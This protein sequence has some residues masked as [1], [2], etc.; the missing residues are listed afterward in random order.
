MTINL[1]D[2]RKALGETGYVNAIWS[3][4]DK[5]SGPIPEPHIRGWR[6]NRAKVIPFV[7]RQAKA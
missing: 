1:R 4:R 5:E 7:K 3:M 6:W 2:L